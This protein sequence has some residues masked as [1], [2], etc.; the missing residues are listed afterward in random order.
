LVTTL[1]QQCRQSQITVHRIIETSWDNEALL[2]EALNINDEIQKVLKRY[3]E[4]MKKKKKHEPEGD[5]APHFREEK[6]LVRRSGSSRSGNRGN[7]D[8]ML[9]DLD[10]MIFGKRGGFDE[11][12]YP[13]KQH[14]ST[15]DDLI[16]F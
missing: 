6:A 4:M 8:D 9:D 5:E 13:K 2:C 12:Q 14:S 16:S 1:V 3:E 10:E 15:K 11:E 7:Q